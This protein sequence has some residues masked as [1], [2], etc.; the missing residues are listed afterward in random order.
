MTLI[1]ELK[2]KGY[3]VPDYPSNLSTPAEK[4]IAARY[5]KA[6]GSAVNPVLRQGNSDRRVALPV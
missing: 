5:S 3:N 1:K 6:L 4:D 2:S